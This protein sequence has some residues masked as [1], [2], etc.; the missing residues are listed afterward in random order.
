MY[1]YFCHC[2]VYNKYILAAVNDLDKKYVLEIIELLKGVSGW[3][4]S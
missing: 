4:K 1:F 3:S 2:P